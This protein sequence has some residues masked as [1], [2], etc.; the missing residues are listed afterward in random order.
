M[1]LALS[2]AGL[3]VRLRFDRPMTDEEL[4][5][6]CAENET[7]HVER[8]AKGELIVMSPTGSEGSGWNSEIITDLNL[9]ARQDGRGKVFDSN[10]G[11][12]LPDGSMRAPDAA[13]VLLRRWNALSRE[14]QKRFAP[15]CPEF[16]IEVRSETDKLHDL[17]AKMEMW[18]A[19]GAEV[20]W[21]ID[22][23]EK[24]VTIYRPGE[25]PE[26]LAQPTSVQGTGPIAGFELVLARIWA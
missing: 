6:F 10:G 21:L 13:W 22:P 14:D 25:Q 5:R 12:T 16:V 8:D 24:A 2:D 18:I 11:F 26:L 23:L 7:V 4:M 17:Q 20:A 15:I 9:W 3:P 19:N 1:N